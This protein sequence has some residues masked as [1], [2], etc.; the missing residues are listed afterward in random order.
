MLIS[1]GGR[2]RGEQPDTEKLVTQMSDTLTVISSENGMRSYLFEAPLMER[3]ELAREPYMEFRR[4]VYIE[5]YK[6]SS[7]L[8]ES[9]LEADYAIF[10]EKL[11]LW[12]A[13][14]NV[15]AVNARGEILETQQLFWNQRTKKIYSNVDT[16]VTRNSDVIIGVGFESDESFDYFFRR[17]RGKVTVDTEPTANPDSAA[18]ANPA[19]PSPGGE[20]YSIKLPDDPG[21]P[22]RRQPVQRRSLGPKRLPGREIPATDL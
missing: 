20:P 21:L 17:P 6:D 12:E 16:K 19:A 1:C 9:T 4:G 2:E 22:E 11:K 14:G 18:A 3:Y 8:V 10:W 13:K 15:V 7:R 5:T